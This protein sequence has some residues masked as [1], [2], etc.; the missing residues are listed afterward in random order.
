MYFGV[1][2]HF[3]KPK[4]IL[5]AY[6]QNL[7]RPISDELIVELEI[8]IDS[9]TKFLDTLKQIVEVSCMEEALDFNKSLTDAERV[10]W[11]SKLKWI[12]NSSNS[13]EEKLN[14]VE[15]LWASF[16]YP[17][18]WRTFIYY[19]PKEHQHQSGKESVYRDLLKFL[20]QIQI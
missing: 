18:E 6:F 14:Q 20:D 9:E 19:L 7:L 17:D 10:W 3:I 2:N 11:F 5:N 13:V 15:S 12:V 4:E 1:K 16:G 8:N